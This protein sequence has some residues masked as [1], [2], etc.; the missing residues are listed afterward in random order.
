MSHKES[1]AQLAGVIAGIVREHGWT[2]EEFA[3]RAGVNRHTARKILL[4]PNGVGRLHNATIAGCAKALGVTVADL[5]ERAANPY[6]AASQPELRD[7]LRRHPDRLKPQEVDELYSL[8]GTGGP[9]TRE[10][11]DHFAARIERR[12]RIVEQVEA[13]AGTEYLDLLEQLVAAL[14]QQVQLPWPTP[15][16]RPRS[17]AD[18]APGDRPGP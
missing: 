9:A 16:R 13:I 5:H 17:R 1:T 4:D 8:Q 15:A 11:I 6:E 2:Q 14:Y 3:R 18:A 10:G 12:R 7:W